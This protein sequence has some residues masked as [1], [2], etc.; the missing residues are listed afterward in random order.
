MDN[1]KTYKRENN[2]VNIKVERFNIKDSLKES[3]NVADKEFL[4]QLEIY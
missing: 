4:R 1:L 3:E 2:V